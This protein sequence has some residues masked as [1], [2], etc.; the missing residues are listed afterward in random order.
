MNC[1]EIKAVERDEVEEDEFLAALKQVL[2]AP[3]RN[4]RSENHEPTRELNRRYRLERR[5]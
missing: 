1:R 2:L 4:V 5:D 3:Q